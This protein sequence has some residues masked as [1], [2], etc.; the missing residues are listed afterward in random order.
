VQTSPAVADRVRELTTTTGT[1]TVTLL[2]AVNGFA[3]FSTAFPAAST[4]VYYCIATTLPGD[5]EVGIGTFTLSGTT[6]SR[7]TVISSSNAGAL[8]N[9]SAGTKD[10]FVTMPASKMQELTKFTVSATPPDDP[11]SGD[12]WLCTSDGVEYTW[13]MDGTSNQWADLGG[14]SLISAN[15]NVPT[16]I[17]DTQPVADNQYLWIQTGLGEDG[18][19]ITLWINT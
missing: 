12:R 2:G 13:Y 18:T 10:V 7:T 16:Y 15:A 14:N 8:V 19:G 3:S 11:G 4:E 6:L 9:F 17:G 5:W 1:G